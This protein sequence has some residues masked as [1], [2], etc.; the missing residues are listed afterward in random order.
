MWDRRAQYLENHDGDTVKM[1]LDQGFGDTKLVDVRLMGVFAPELHDV[2]G[3]ECRAFVQAWFE[4]RLRETRW[5][6]VVI[7]ARMKVADREQKTL[8]RYV[9]TVTSLDGTDNLNLEVMQFIVSKGYS[10]GTGA[11]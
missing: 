8:D 3:P 2:G 4:Y 9:G 7:T 1:A 11:P 5:G 6:F 10:G